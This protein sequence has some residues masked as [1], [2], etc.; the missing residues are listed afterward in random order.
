MDCAV[1]AMI[2]GVSL[3]LSLGMVIVMLVIW[4]GR[5]DG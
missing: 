2:A 5:R 4:M 1:P 3:G